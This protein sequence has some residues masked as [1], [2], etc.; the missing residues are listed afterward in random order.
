MTV[1]TRFAP[2][3][4]GHLHLGHAYSALFSFQAAVQSGGQFIVR[5]ED[6]DL[7]RCRPE[8][9][10][11]ILDDLAWLGLTWRQPVRRQS[12]HMDD[13]QDAIDKLK[14]QDLLYPC[15]CTR[16]EIKAE[17]NAAGHAPHGP[18]GPLY[19]G[20]CR[21]VSTSERA[22]R[23]AA[24]DAFALRLDMK[25]ASQQA[26]P[27]QWGDSEKGHIKATPEVFGD[28]VLARK[29]VPTSYHIAV[30]HDDHL[31]N[32]SLVTRGE[33]LFEATHV[34]CLLQR[35]LGYD[36]PDYHH[37]KLLTGSDGKRYAKRDKSLTLN[38]LRNTSTTRDDVF[39]LIGWETGQ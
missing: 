37:H 15:F 4:T 3:P 1:T 7:G 12:D 32:I 16:A 21:G 23:I 39:K 38:S 24:G 22:D 14:Q 33:D 27:L 11:S 17:I 30:T 10:Q 36:S 2:S 6:I 5:I 35:L 19:P 26:G 25:R 31:Q 28:V 9:E 13:Y 34:H 20:T 8:Y 29:D 18:D